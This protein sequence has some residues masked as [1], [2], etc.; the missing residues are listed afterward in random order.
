MRFS[1]FARL[2]QDLDDKEESNREQQ[3]NLHLQATHTLVRRYEQRTIQRN[4]IVASQLASFA[5]ANREK[6]RLVVG[7]FEAFGLGCVFGQDQSVPGS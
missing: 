4:A 7:G 6:L 2:L 5:N 3:S 1:E